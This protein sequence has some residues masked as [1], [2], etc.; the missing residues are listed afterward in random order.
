MT[1]TEQPQALGPGTVLNDR[2]EVG[3]PIGAGAMGSV[4]R[5]H[6][7]N[8]GGE[9][10]IKVLHP[11]LV[12]SREYVT[13]FKRE[14]LA[15]SRFRH[16]SA[17]KVLGSGETDDGLPFIV[18]ELVEGRNL[19]EI[20][21]SEGS[22]PIG[23]ACNIAAQLL[24]A[25]GAA[26]QR[27]IVH[28][29]MKPENVRVVMDEDGIE[30]PKI[31]DFGIVKFIGG[32]LEDMDGAVKTKT[33][34]VLG[35]PKYMAPEQVRGEAVDGRAD[36]YAVG[37]VT[38]EMLTGEPP[39]VADD[40]F[41]FVAMHLKQAVTPL[42]HKVPE[43][44]IPVE[45]DE[46]VLHMLEKDPSD[47]PTDA[48]TL[49]DRLEHWAVEDP[50]AG[51]KVRAL[52]VAMGITA[53]SGVV[54]AVAAHFVAPNVDVAAGAAG[55]GLG[56]GAAVAARFLPRPSVGGYVRRVAVVATALAAI[57]GISLLVPASQGFYTT[58]AQGLAALLTYVAYLTVWNQSAR[59]MRFLAAGV[60]APLV[61]A[62]LV[63]MRVVGPAG[64]ATYFVHAFGGSIKGM[65]AFEA[66][67]RTSAVLAVALVA[68][69]FAAASL[70]LPKAGAARV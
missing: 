28:R 17:V 7:R 44:D 5:G 65:E 47:R 35:T 42:T 12:T 41:G 22:L 14:A 1:G 27:G 19:K 51:E 46:V 53:A 32:E 15:A 33:G 56:L 68:V 61:S 16:E 31:L 25:L 57:S 13:R 70:T 10:A 62:M 30:R 58:A 39:F 38:Y 9:V 2:F 69:T 36:I 48:A 59:W 8:A 40:I 4:Y 50:R 49:A 43:K 66:T 21:E 29:D 55:V 54:V 67:A 26:H 60:V 45:L 18:M 63:P 34:V 11:R 23:R 20:L 64:T 37:A 24:R 52:H 3:E 6:D